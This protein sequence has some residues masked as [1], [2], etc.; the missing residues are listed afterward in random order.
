MWRIIIATEKRQLRLG[1]FLQGVGHHLAAWRHPDVDPR[2]TL[3]F[4]FYQQLART[5]ERGKFDAIF[6]ADSLGVPDGPPELLARGLL[7]SYLEPLTNL[8]AIAGV[9]ERIGLIATVS[10]SYLPPFHLARKFA[11]L[12]QLSNGRT[13]WNLVT[14]GTD[15]EARNFNLDTQ[16]PHA[17]RYR[18]AREYVDVVKG[19]WDG[20]SDDALLFD[21]QAGLMF[22]PA[23]L[24]RLNHKGE[25]YTVRGPLVAERPVQGYPVIVQAGSSGDGQALAAATAEV[26]FTAQQTLEEG[27]RFYAG[28]KEQ[29]IPHGR[30]ADS[31]KIMP[32]VLPVIGR[33][34]QEAQDKY[35][36]LQGLI[37][38]VL[39]IGLLNAFLGN[40]DLSKYPLDGPVPE[41]PVTEG[42][43]SRQKLF[44]DLARRENLSLRQL[45][46]RVAGARGHRIVIGTAEHVADQLEEWF[47]NGAA[48]GFN[49]LPPTLPHGLDDFVNLVV[50]ELQR[51]GLFRTE[52]IGRTLR[53]HLGLQRPRNQFE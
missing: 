50:P 19:L 5:A 47:V 43:Q 26:V 51:R 41:L 15:W 17:E 28:L 39:G 8:A 46:Q 48:D 33:S 20:W 32:G 42:W 9:T 21:Q 35:E 36:Q 44:V 25:R 37:D 14:S 13:G 24:Y 18:H 45:Y 22:D 6:F 23:K 1:A 52:Y 31:L 49:I 27:R 16:T 10:T 30:S 34:A 29:L 7:P 11:S 12:D 3:R 4:D 2:N 53:E 40:I 38:P